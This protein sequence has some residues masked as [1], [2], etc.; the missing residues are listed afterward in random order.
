MGVIELGQCVVFQAVFLRV[1]V[2]VHMDSWW[3]QK[4]CSAVGVNWHLGKKVNTHCAVM[5]VDLIV[6]FKVEVV[7][8]QS[9][10]HLAVHRVVY[11]STS[12]SAEATGLK[13][14]AF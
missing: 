1:A 2:Q 3:W 4:S 12:G 5:K 7:L 14:K 13:K 8:Y 10:E 9:R 11:T 6:E